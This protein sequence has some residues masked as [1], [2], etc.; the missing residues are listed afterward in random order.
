[1]G[2]DLKGSGC[3][4]FKVLPGRTEVNYGNFSQNFKYFF[5]IRKEC[6]SITPIRSFY[7][8]DLSGDCRQGFDWRMDLL[9]T[10]PNHSELQ[11]STAI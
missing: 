4:L 2:K 3:G 1:M 7:C 5:D 11:V 10:G 9:A 8:Y 6:L